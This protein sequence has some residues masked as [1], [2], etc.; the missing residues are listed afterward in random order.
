MSKLDEK[1]MK[2][3]NWYPLDNAAKIYPPISNPRRAS[4]FSLTAVLTE[5]VDK[6]TLQQATNEILNRFVSFNVKLKRGIFWYYLEENNRPFTVQEEPPFFLKYIDQIENNGYLF[7]VFYKHNHI[8]ME[9]FHSLADGTG[10]LDVFKSL[11]FEYL[12]LS[13]KKVEGENKILTCFTPYTSDES[14]DAFMKLCDKTKLKPEKEKNAFHTDGTP[15][16]YDGCGIITGKI[17][18]AELKTECK[19]YDATITA[20]LSGL[21]MYCIYENFIKGKKVNNKLVKLLVPINMRKIYDTKTLRNFAMFC[22]LGHNFEEEITLDECIEICKN[23][24]K[25]GLDKKKLDATAYSNVKQEKNWF[26]KIVPL[27]LKVIVLRLAYNYVGDNLH[28]ANVSNLG[29]V[30]LPESMKPYVT[31]FVFT[32]APSYSC[33]T[34]LALIGYDDHITA[35]FSRLFVENDLEKM[36]FTTLTSKGIS[37]EISSNYWEK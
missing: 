16:N 21:Y 27:F 19:K 25:S 32:L 2:R 36:F 14:N 22:R 18:T 1:Y 10:A 4:T 13:G 23:E 11:V 12:L 24:L 29:L 6:D 33:K 37:V 34:H 9:V 35:S 3:K 15:F 7:R 17:N 8:T 5:D 30:D 20:Y 26:L 28:T 31:D